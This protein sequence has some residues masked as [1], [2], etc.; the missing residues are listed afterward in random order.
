M[1]V[2]VGTRGSKLAVTQAKSFLK[3]LSFTEYDYDLIVI[4]TVGDVRQEER[5][6]ELGVKGIFTKELDDALLRKEIDFAI[7]SLKDI[8]SQLHPQ[9]HL[10]AVSPCLD[11][12]DAFI[13][14]KYA[15][16]ETMPANAVVGTSSVRR[17]AQILSRRPD[18]VIKEL[19]GNVE[20]RIHKMTMGEYD[21]ILLAASGVTRVGMESHIKQYLDPTVY[22]PCIGQGILAATALIENSRIEKLLKRK[23]QPHDM[24]HALILREFMIKAQGGCSVPLGCHLE[25]KNDTMQMWGYLSDPKGKRMILESVQEPA[26]QKYLIVHHLL[27]K[28]EK[29]GMR[30]I[31]EEIHG[32]RG[33]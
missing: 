17:Q 22:V 26:E 21:A 7:H 19:R 25:M 12:R 13:S 18:L 20:T 6:T 24:I 30:S 15:S 23:E 14:A 1:K 8:P 9:I 3:D 29:K 5:F 4:K 10:A 27:D 31:L 28:M 33:A 11:S 16:I 32:Q 2:R